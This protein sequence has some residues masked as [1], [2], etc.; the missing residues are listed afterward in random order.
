VKVTQFV[1]AMEQA[2]NRLRSIAA[3]IGFDA[4]GILAG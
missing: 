3:E 4:R 1:D 2:K